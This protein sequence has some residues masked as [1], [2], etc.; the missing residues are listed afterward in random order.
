MEKFQEKESIYKKMKE[1]V[2]RQELKRLSFFSIK[3]IDRMDSC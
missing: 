2:K 1:Y 3:Y